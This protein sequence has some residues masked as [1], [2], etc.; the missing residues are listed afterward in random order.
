MFLRIVLLL[1]ILVMAVGVGGAVF[2]VSAGSPGGAAVRV[3]RTVAGGPVS[4]DPRPV[5]FAVKQ[6]ETAATIGDQLAGAGLVRS[7]LAFRLAVRF[8]GE[9]AHLEAGDYELRPNMALADVIG[10]LAQGRM[11]GGLF[12]VPEGWRALEIADAL[13]RSGVGDRTD[14]LQIVLHPQ[15]SLSPLVPLIPAGHPLEGYLYPDSYRF[16]P[17]TPADQIILQ[18]LDNF[19]KHL[20]PD[21]LDGYRAQGLDLN[22]AVTLASIVER[23]A[24]VPSERPEIASVFYN[25]LHQRMPLQADPTVQYALVADSTAVDPGAYWKRGLT[26]AD[27]Q[28]PSPYNT[29]QVDGLPPGPICNPGLA[30]LQAVAHPD[31]TEYLFF[32]ARRDGTHAFAKTLAEH[33]QN[34]AKYQ[35]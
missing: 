10:T 18:M 30:S 25:R 29:Y 4:P 14:F 5:H 20:A 33:E 12:T 11:S 9:S 6:G 15:P 22:Q 8:G 35:S 26:L 16:G 27:L 32:V 3:I 34:V 1:A 2:V 7:G 24:V 21:L 17:N 19:Q 28:V 13:P 23:E 31:S